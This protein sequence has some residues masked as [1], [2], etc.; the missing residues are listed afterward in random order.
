[1]FSKTFALD[2]IERAIKS[3]AQA[4]ILAIGA[5]EGFDLFAADWF[6]VAGIA[7]GAFVLSALTSI[8]SEPFG[9]KGTASVTDGTGGK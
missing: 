9:R 2:L 1:M 5:A 6:N 4:I 3:A 7:A 8:A